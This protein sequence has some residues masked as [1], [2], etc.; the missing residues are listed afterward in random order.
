MIAAAL[1]SSS[2]SELLLALATWLTAWSGLDPAMPLEL[3]RRFA[4]ISLSHGTTFVML[5]S[6][7]VSASFVLGLDKEGRRQAVIVALVASLVLPLKIL[8]Q[9]RLPAEC[10]SS[11][12]PSA[13]IL[14]GFAV[15]AL[16]IHKKPS[17]ETAP[18]TIISLPLLIACG[19]VTFFSVIPGLP[20]AGLALA[21]AAFC[22]R[23]AA[24][25]WE[26]ALAA[27]LPGW[28]LWAFH[29]GREW[30]ADV[31]A[32][33]SPL[34]MVV[35]LMLLVFSGLLLLPRLVTRLSGW[36]LRWS[37]WA[38]LLL[39]LLM[40]WLINRQM[41]HQQR[42]CEV[43]GTGAEVQFWCDPV[44]ADRFA[45]IVFDE[46]AATDLEL[47]LY[48]PESE[49]SR[50]NRDAAQHDFVCSERLWQNLVAAEQ[51]WK[52]SQG[53]F[54]VT[55]GPLM[56]LWGFYGKKKSEPS[57]AE[58]DEV[59]KRTGFQYVRLDHARHTCRFL[60]PGIEID[61]GGIAK[62]LAV[63]RA[64]EKLQKAGCRRGLV[65]LAG[66]LRVF[67]PPP[68]HAGAY[69]IGVKDPRDKNAVLASMKLLNQSTSTS[70]SYERFVIYQGKKW[71]HILDPHNG[72]PK[73]GADSVSIVCPSALW[74]D[75][76]S[77][78]LFVAGPEA[79]AAFEPVAGPISFLWV[80][81]QE[82]APAKIV[83]GGSSFI[84][85]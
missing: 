1:N 21:L 34:I 14:C 12:L 4:M 19:G 27:A 13:W 63:D 52:L 62:G 64:V 78:T 11:L 85:P 67:G 46:F 23:P 20:A 26:L 6:V 54:D 45:K 66:N 59:L 3:G 58:I 33:P 25:A 76:L 31:S 38:A 41:P 47:S 84:Q 5:L 32:G 7:L 56:R 8:A 18:D 24:Q 81:L 42:F 65:D 16:L 80:D 70:G 40:M 51:A 43:M 30:S 83:R 39:S 48:K 50:L 71:P 37:A 69:A 44:E 74:A 57:E 60:K 53:S 2:V 17:G 68:P 49:L 75:I 15:A 35:T 36:G 22:R 79:A 9:P 82:G 77:T 55:V 29:S 72:R 61:L 10:F 73:L 28:G